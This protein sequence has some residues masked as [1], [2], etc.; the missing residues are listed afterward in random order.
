MT[1][2]WWK[3]APKPAPTLIAIVLTA[4]A[5]SPFATR[6]RAQDAPAP[7][8]PADTSAVPTPGSPPP[9]IP[10]PAAVP[11][12]AAPAVD[13]KVA[14][15]QEEARRKEIADKEKADRQAK[16]LAA[17]EDARKAGLPW[18]KGANWMSFRLGTA[19]SKV[20]NSPNASVGL[21]FGAQHFRSS[22]WSL[23][24]NADLDVLGRFGGASE[25]EIPLTLEA[26]RHMRW[27]SDTVRPFIGVGTGVWYHRFY[28][29]GADG[30]EV[31]PGFF[32]SGGL[33][34][35]ISAG[36]VLGFVGRMTVQS[37]A[38]TDNPYFPNES[39]SAVHWS[40]KLSYM[41]V[42]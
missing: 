19:G 38:E 23:G 4:S 39:N 14:E 12:P 33:N 21:G 26:Q 42:R 30:T 13:P 3:R 17:I 35:P 5:F 37:N 7:A 20:E 27:G 29:T 41:R 36:S 9:A 8:A 18:F 16:E 40:L 11:P 24:M 31:R 1:K 6:A 28:R 10:A 2:W 22:N 32:L 34:S 15:A 25:M